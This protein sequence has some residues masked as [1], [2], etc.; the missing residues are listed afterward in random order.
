MKKIFA[1]ALILAAVLAWSACPALAADKK[2]VDP[3]TASFTQIDQDDDGVIM[4]TEVV[5]LYP[6]GGAELHRLMDRDKDGKVTKEEW[7]AWKKKY[8]GQKPVA[9]AVRYV[10]LDTD[11]DGNVVANEFI[12]VFGPESKAIF[13]KADKNKDGKLSKEEFEALKKK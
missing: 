13:D 8:A 6:Q 10:E 12:A 11:A 5:A 3:F 4:V 9:T 7:E 1:L 2:K